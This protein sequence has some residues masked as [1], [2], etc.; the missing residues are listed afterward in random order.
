MNKAGVGLLAGSDV[1]EVGLVGGFSLHEELISLQNAGLTPLEAIK[2]A[3]INPAKYQNSAHKLGT[4]EKGKIADLVLLNSNPLEDIHNTQEI[5]SVFTNGQYLNRMKL[6][7]LLIGV[8][9]YV[10]NKD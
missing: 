3:T 8:E 2:T 10:K 7:S 6:D 9:N 5:N 1:G 4:I